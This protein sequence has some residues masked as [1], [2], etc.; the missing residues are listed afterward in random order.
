MLFNRVLYFSLLLPGVSFSQDIV[1]Q[2]LPTS[3][4]DRWV[5]DVEARSGSRV[6]PD[7]EHWV[8]EQTTV[9]VE[10]IPEGTLLIQ[11]VR[12]LN[13]T[14]PLLRPRVAGES[15]ILIHG[16]CIYYVSG[17]QHGWGW[18]PT[19]HQL[20]AKFREYF[21]RGEIL[22]S[23]C[24]PLRPGQ[25]WGDPK[26]GRDLWTVAGFGPKSQN[27][28]LPA[29]PEAWRLEANLASGDDNYVWFQKGLGVI[30]KRD[31]HNGTY[32]D[33]RVRLLRFEP[34]AR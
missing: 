33:R 8:E 13:N 30:A 18:D 28:P 34:A 11:K 16:A 12:F 9:A 27:D 15:A 4:G 14:A 25:I 23:A 3:V 20:G 1:R 29:G 17:G 7:V 26:K 31:Y 19:Q 10:N 6:H 24:F 22:A 2:W 5:Y 21:S 32:D